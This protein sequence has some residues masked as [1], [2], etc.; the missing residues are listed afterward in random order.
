MRYSLDHIFEIKVIKFTLLQSGAL[1][2]LLPVAVDRHCNEKDHGNED[3]RNDDV[4]R[5]LVFPLKANRADFPLSVAEYD[6]KKTRCIERRVKLVR[7][8]V[9]KACAEQFLTVSSIASELVSLGWRLK[10]DSGGL[11][12]AT[13]NSLSSSRIVT[14]HNT[15]PTNAWASLAVMALEKPLPCI[16][17]KKLRSYWNQSPFKA[18]FKEASKICRQQKYLH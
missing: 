2:G 17:E 7:I 14:G 3:S 12:G 9:I 4:K 8:T 11:E 1:R 15:S 10:L 16:T 18:F 5:N 6:L 13:R